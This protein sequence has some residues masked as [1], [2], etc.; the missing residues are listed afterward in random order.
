MKTI[1]NNKSGKA[2]EGETEVIVGVGWYRPEHWVKLLEV[3]ID[4]DSLEKTYE[5]W[6]HFAEK[7]L[8]DLQRTTG[9]S[10]KKVYIDIMELIAWCKSKQRPVNAAARAEFAQ[11]LLERRIKEG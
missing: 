7:A 6:L 4:R 3:S 9:I 8:F 2:E 5:E 10:P 11:V 1:K